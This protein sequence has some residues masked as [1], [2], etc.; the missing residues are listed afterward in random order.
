VRIDRVPPTISA[1]RTPSAN[2]AGWNK[3]AVTVEFTCADALSGIASCAA[4]KLLN[5]EGAA[6]SASGEATDLAGNTA[7]ASAAGIN[8]DL[9][10]PVVGITGV[11]NGAVYDLGAV[12]Q[13]GCSTTDALSGVAVSAIVSVTGGTSNGV[14]SYTVSCNGAVDVAGNTN[15][16]SAT[17]A[18][19]YVFNGF[20]TPVANL[21]ATNAVKAGQTVPVKFGLGGDRGLGVL[22]GGTAMS[23]VISCTAALTDALIE[24][25]ATNPGASQF[26]FD[27]ITGLYQFNWKTDKAWAN[28]CRRL[29]VRLDDGTVH[30]A[31]FHLK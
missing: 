16:A 14:G 10:P 1:S 20:M 19:H 15:A 13:A 2:P 7:S 3:G 21:P 4:S 22:S 18:V 8:I 12:P 31:D 27:P 28:S 6:Q 23:A 29:L 25:P 24:V 11:T 30:S 17:F 5:T 9:T 26:S